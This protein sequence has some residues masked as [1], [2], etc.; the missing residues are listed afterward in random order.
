MHKRSIFSSRYDFKRQKINQKWD[1]EFRKSK[2]FP[3]IVENLTNVTDFTEISNIEDKPKPILNKNEW[4]DSPKIS[5]TDRYF[6]EEQFEVEFLDKR[7]RE[8]INLIIF[9]AEPK[10]FK[11]PRRQF[12]IEDLSI[13]DK[14]QVLEDFFNVEVLDEAL[15]DL[16]LKKIIEKPK[17]DRFFDK[18]PTLTSQDGKFICFYCDK[19]FKRSW[20]LSNHLK[21]HKGVRPYLCPLCH[22]AFSDLSNL[23]SHQRSK[24]HHDWKFACTQ[25]SKPF[26]NVSVLQCIFQPQFME[27]AV[28]CY[29][30]A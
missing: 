17:P 11:N 6:L 26:Q 15:Q 9:D 22:M 13:S 29:E 18:S 7:E 2:L 5:I 23:R 10:K 25:C 21:L 4:Y 1:L 12:V 20:I 8:T 19:R 24:S 16:N 14:I 30:R 28:V 3:K 27:E